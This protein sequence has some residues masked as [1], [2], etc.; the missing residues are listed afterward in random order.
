MYTHTHKKNQKQ[1]QSETRPKEKQTGLEKEPII[2]QRE[3]IKLKPGTYTFIWLS[4]WA[5]ELVIRPQ[6]TGPDELSVNITPMMVL[7]MKMM[8]IM[9]MMM[10]MGMMVEEKINWQAC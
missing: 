6:Q 10:I 4:V 7:M 3:I 2:V 5:F 8:T 9:I 1:R